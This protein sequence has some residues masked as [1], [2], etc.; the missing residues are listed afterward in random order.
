[1][2]K[3]ICVRC[4]IYCDD[5]FNNDTKVRACCSEETCQI[6]SLRI[7]K[8]KRVVLDRGSILRR[9]GK[10]RHFVNRKKRMFTL[11]NELLV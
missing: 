8:T 1:M 5:H 7:R 10:V 9:T 11:R 2:Q 6:V 4:K 3:E